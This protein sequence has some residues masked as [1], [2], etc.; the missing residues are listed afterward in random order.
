MLGSAKQTSA[1][2]LNRHRLVLWGLTLMLCVGLWSCGSSVRRPANVSDLQPGDEATLSGKIT[3]VSPPV[4]IQALGQALERYQPQVKILSPTPNQVL[5]DDQVTVQFQV[6]DLPLFKNQEFGL[7]PH[8]HV[9]LDNQPYQAVYDPT[10]PLTLS[11]LTPGTHTL[12]AIA[13]RPWHELFKNDGSYAQVTF[14]VFTKTLDNNPDAQQPLITYSRPQGSYGAEPIMLDFYLTNV[15]L[16][17][18]A[19]EQ[20]DDDI[21]DWRIR[22]TVNGQSF[23]FDEWLPIY[24]K[25]FSRG[26]NWVQLELLDEAGNAIANTFNNTARII[27]YE[28]GGSDTLSQ[29]VRGEISVAK[30]KG[31]V[32]PNYIYVPEPEP[33][34]E[35]EPET[36]PEPTPL[37]TPSPEPLPLPEAPSDS[38]PPAPSAET[39][40]SSSVQDKQDKGESDDRISSDRPDESSSE[41]SDEFPSES[42]DN[43]PIPIPQQLRQ[44]NPAILPKVVAPAPATADDVED[45]QDFSTIEDPANADDLRLDNTAA[46]DDPLSEESSLN[47]AETNPTGVETE[48]S[49]TGLP[50]AEPD[51]PP[52]RNRFFQT[53]RNRAAQFR[54]QTKESVKP[55]SEERSLEPVPESA[56]SPAD[57]APIPF[58]DPLT[59]PALE[60]T[61]TLPSRTRPA[62]IPPKSSDDA[63]SPRAVLSPIPSRISPSPTVTA[64]RQVRDGRILEEGAA[65]RNESS[66][67]RPYIEEPGSLGIDSLDP[68]ETL[69]AE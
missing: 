48:R 20:T 8:L 67:S 40:R 62:P 56:D 63:S 52:Q 19:Q 42:S 35:P 17:L 44:P 29:L 12:R 53:L 11:G 49:P 50:S 61:L 23:V 26:K 33:T 37:P 55:S 10:Q 54:Q 43:T 15:P 4:A 13:S 5:K 2:R 34:P 21:K 7:G 3:E 59:E 69:E 68:V 22:A 6:M 66:H 1:K 27:N 39:E 41:F 47:E 57:P 16:H 32:D 46:P 51:A 28:P 14:H 65:A 36:S 24:L 45:L 18:I 25:G 30:V 64:P 38:Q 60:P 9:F 31:I 58:I